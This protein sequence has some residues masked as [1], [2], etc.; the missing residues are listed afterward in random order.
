MPN[1]PVEFLYFILVMGLL[2]DKLL[3]MPIL[4]LLIFY[5]LLFLALCYIILVFLQLLLQITFLSFKLFD[6]STHVVL[7]VIFLNY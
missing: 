4:F 7:F 6:L 2:F 3:F 5:C 1:F